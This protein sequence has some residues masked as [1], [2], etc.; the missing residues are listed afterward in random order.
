MDRRTDAES[1]SARQRLDEA[2]MY[3]W[4]EL[5][6]QRRRDASCLELLAGAIVL[7]DLALDAPVAHDPCAPASRPMEAS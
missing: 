5:C 3:E 1:K 6:M 4:G 7:T 2:V